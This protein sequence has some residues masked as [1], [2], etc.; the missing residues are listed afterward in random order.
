M[1]GRNLLRKSGP[2][3][4]S[5]PLCMDP[6]KDSPPPSSDFDRLISEVRPRLRAFLLSLTGSQACAEDLTQET[7]LILWEKRDEYDPSRSFRS[8]AFRIGFLQ[9]QNYRRKQRR[10]QERELPGDELFEQI[11]DTMADRH[12]RD[13]DEDARHQAMIQC[14]GKLNGPHRNLVLSRYRDERSLEQLSAEAGINR[15]A[16]AQKLFR[17]KRTLLRCIEKQRKTIS[18]SSPL[19]T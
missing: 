14:L 15:N 5:T 18:P 1:D 11:A 2:T 8:W 16:M 9:A 3:G 4:P 12:G 7:S 17:L 13:D 10:I 19:S 6:L